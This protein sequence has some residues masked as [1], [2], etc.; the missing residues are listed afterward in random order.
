MFKKT[1]DLAEVGTP[2]LRVKKV[3]PQLIPGPTKQKLE[4]EKNGSCQ[5]IRD[6]AAP[7]CCCFFWH[8]FDQLFLPAIPRPP[9]CP[10]VSWAYFY[11]TP[12]NQPLRDYLLPTKYNSLD[13]Q[14]LLKVALLGFTTDFNLCSIYYRLIIDFLIFYR[15][16]LRTNPENHAKHPPNWWGRHAFTIFERIFCCCQLWDIFSV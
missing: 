12:D 5:L 2:K 8:F 14:I 6:P 15:L 3:W 9:I 7:G 13:V 1:A 10:P 11:C 16:S 4:L